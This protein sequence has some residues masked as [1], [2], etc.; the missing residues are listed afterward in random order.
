MSLIACIGS[1]EVGPDEE[2]FMEKIGE[3][4]VRHGHTIKT[5]NALG[6]DQAYARGGNRVDPSKVWLYL[7]WSSYEANKIVPG[8]RVISGQEAHWF[9]EAEKFHPAWA[10]L[11]DPVR[12][13]MARNIGI[14]ENTRQ[15]IARLNHSKQ[16]GGGTGHGV[17]YALANQ[18]DVIDISRHSGISRIVAILE[19]A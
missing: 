10:N 17:R 16:G 12:K 1:R 7:P 11:K 4:L 2:K 5:G 19:K 15:V 6:S 9:T 18:I 8:N 3:W 13:L 14:V